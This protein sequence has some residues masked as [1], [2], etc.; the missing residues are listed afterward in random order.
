MDFDK[1]VDDMLEAEGHR[2]TLP[3]GPRTK[4]GPDF[5]IMGWDE[6][7]AHLEKLLGIKSTGYSTGGG[8]TGIGFE[9]DGQDVA[10]EQEENDDYEEGGDEPEF[11]EYIYTTDP[12]GF[13]PSVKNLI[14]QKLF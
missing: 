12:K 10:I 9:I 2:I 6:A 8:L 14:M 3:T 4:L 7:Q 1:A 13:K 5:S 11:I